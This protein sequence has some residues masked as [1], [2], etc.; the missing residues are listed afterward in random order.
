MSK[1]E[2]TIEINGSYYLVAPWAGNSIDS[3]DIRI[4]DSTNSKYYIVKVDVI[5][6]GIYEPGIL[7]S[8]FADQDIM[9]GGYIAS[10][11]FA[12]GLQARAKMNLIAADAIPL[13]FL[14]VVYK[15][16]TRQIDK[17][18]YA[19]PT[20]YEYEIENPYIDEENYKGHRYIH[21]PLTESIT[22]TLSYSK[23]VTVQYEVAI[24]LDIETGVLFVNSV[25]IF[26][27]RTEDE[28]TIGVIG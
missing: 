28:K 24:D 6:N 21:R 27:T 15:N 10:C 17:K 1:N 25:S 19:M 14:T 20:G 18:M 8:V 5:N 12:F 3:S 9:V 2:K 13:S 22:G 23:T 7:A 26:T 4:K 16:G 11:A